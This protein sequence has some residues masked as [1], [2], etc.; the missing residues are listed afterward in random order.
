MPLIGFFHLLIDES[1]LGKVLATQRKVAGN[2]RQR[3]DTNLLKEI[4]IAAVV[5]FPLHNRVKTT[6]L[7]LHEFNETV[8]F[9]LTIIHCTQAPFGN[10]LTHFNEALVELV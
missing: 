4:L 7:L 6:G 5:R 9:K 10:A 1:H 2:N 8:A 3:V